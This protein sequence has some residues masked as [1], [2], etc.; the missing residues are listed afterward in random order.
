MNKTVKKLLPI[1]L[2]ITLFL[3]VRVNA[4]EEIKMVENNLFNAQLLNEISDEIK[5]I[6]VEEIDGNIKLEWNLVSD[7]VSYNIYRAR[8]AFDVDGYQ[9]IAS[10][11]SDNN[12]LDTSIN[13]G[14]YNNYYKVGVVL[15]GDVEEVSEIYISLETQMFG[16]NMIFI[17]ET[18]DVNAVNQVV[19]DIFRLQNNVLER[20]Q[21]SENRYAIYYKPG[22]YTTTDSIPV[23]FYTHI[24]GLGR[25]PYDVRLNNIEVPAYLDGRPDNPGGYWVDGG[26]WRNATCN[27]WRSAENISVVGVGEASVSLLVTDG[28]SQNWKPNA[29]N[30]SV[31]QAAPLRRIHST[32]DVSYDW[33][34]GW[35][36]GGFT[37]DSYFEGNAGTPSGQQYFTRNSVILGSA[38]GT[39]L[40]NFFIGVESDDIPNAETGVPLINGNGYSNWSIPT[41]SLAQQVTTSITSTPII[42]EKPFLFLDDDGEYKVFVPALRENAIGTSWGENDIGAGEI[43]SIDEFYIAK[44]TD[45]SDIINNQLNNGKNVFFT[46]GVYRADEVIEVNNPNTIV[47]GTGMASIIPGDSN[48]DTA[49]RVADEEGI[50][51]AGLIFDAGLHSKYLLQVGVEGQHNN[52]A[53]N[54]ILLADLFFRVGGTTERLT[55]AD[56][57]LEINSDYVI[58]DHFWIWRADHGYGVAWDGNESARGLIVNGDNV[59]S[60]ALFNEH[61]QEYN[62]LWN[63]DN[64]ATYFYQN[65]TPYDPISQ[66][67]WSSHRGTVN[68]WAQYKVANKVN[69][70]YAVGLGVYNV[71]IN[72]GPDRDSLSVQIELDNAIEVPN[73]EG[74]LIENACIQTF[75]REDGVL[76]KINHIING[77]GESVSSGT[78]P[79]TG[80]VGTGWDRKYI[81]SYQ[82]GVSISGFNGSI[83]EEGQQP[84]NAVGDVDLVALQTLYDSLNP[85]DYTIASWKL[86]EPVLEVVSFQLEELGYDWANQETV[87]QVL[88]EFELAIEQLVSVAELNVL[89]ANSMDLDLSKYT[90]ESQGVFN[91][92]LEKARQLLISEE[93][94]S[95][96]EV[97]TV[98]K[99]LEDAILNLV[100]LD[101]T[102]DE[103]PNSDSG[104]ITP[105]TG[106]NDDLVVLFGML[107]ISLVVL[108]VIRS[109]KKNFLKD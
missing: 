2:I 40:N 39:S 94:F 100:E 25:T 38:S 85:N 33:S 46:P 76:Q 34:F 96:G 27:F 45:T 58:G 75:A 36:S 49:M 80:E 99:V 17:A 48:S 97:D 21:F 86:L 57:A 43:V 42:K 28:I 78:D 51:I 101:V 52:N 60:Y 56:D 67:E 59:I 81:L 4:W 53:N 64:G 62:T 18:D 14:K 87:D 20:S 24:G 102:D 61:F 109:N 66:E 55:K 104:A 37:A 83:I 15:E 105:N 23:G 92:A 107:A 90:I 71:L 68:G 93:H 5:I 95:Q 32:R 22:D 73:K 108:F 91:N 7:A 70:H 10:N 44:E 30:W 89:Y 103:I 50:I 9:L 54:P 47:L 1:L 65:E 6:Q 106:V 79:I 16:P 26:D 12:Y 98:L 35:A 41:D 82:N 31:S 11:V 84:M 77:T 19:Q 3:P 88:I 69:N 8:S 29:F 74:V 13:A 63:G 72:T